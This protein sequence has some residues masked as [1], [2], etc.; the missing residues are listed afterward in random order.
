MFELLQAA[1]NENNIDFNTFT[2]PGS[3]K[4]GNH[5]ELLLSL[6]REMGW[7]GTTRQILQRICILKN[8]TKLSVR[9]ERQVRKLSNDQVLQN[10]PDLKALAYHFPCKNIEDIKKI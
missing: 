1:C 6:K 4:V 3:L 8:D 5:Y 7:V 9:D 10:K 2:F